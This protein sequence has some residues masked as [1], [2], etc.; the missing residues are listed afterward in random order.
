MTQNIDYKNKYLKYK[1]K[2]FNLKK[3]I[4]GSVAKPEGSPKTTAPKSGSKNNLGLEIENY[5]WTTGNFI[6]EPDHWLDYDMDLGQKNRLIVRT[7]KFK[8]KDGTEKS[9]F[10]FRWWNDVREKS[11]KSIKS[12]ITNK[13]SKEVIDSLY[14]EFI[15]KIFD[16]KD[17]D[18]KAYRTFLGK[19]IPAG[20]YIRSVNLFTID[21]G[22]DK[23]KKIHFR[24]DFGLPKKKDELQGFPYDL[25]FEPNKSGG[26]G[27]KT[28]DFVNFSCRWV[29]E[30]LEKDEELSELYFDFKTGYDTKEKKFTFKTVALDAP[31][32][33]NYKDKFAEN[34][35]K[36]MNSLLPRYVKFI[37]TINDTDPDKNIEAFLKSFNRLWEKSRDFYYNIRN[38][39]QDKKNMKKQKKRR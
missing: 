15:G 17:V 6:P 24:L 18:T 14:K 39:Y 4:G 16:I 13:S 28:S 31:E 23:K 27:K 21:V 30:G 7:F 19:T 22:Q 25:G 29:M 35:S 20:E 9:R 5:S 26:I 33:D 34:F 1:S 38:S 8:L 36:N 3:S 32:F 2:F 11:I 12:G 37:H 10:G